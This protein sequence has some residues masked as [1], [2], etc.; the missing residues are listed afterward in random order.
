MEKVAWEKGQFGMHLD[1]IWTLTNIHSQGPPLYNM[2]VH[3]MCC[4]EQY[5][6][7][8]QFGKD[9]EIQQLRLIRS[10]PGDSLSPCSVMF[11][12][13]SYIAL[14]STYMVGCCPVPR[15]L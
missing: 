5:Q 9:L 10:E 15:Q 3:A 4:L 12:S 13:D 6:N 14:V 1:F 2:G 8:R 11:I 7:F